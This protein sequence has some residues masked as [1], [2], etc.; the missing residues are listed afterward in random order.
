[1]Y[2]PFSSDSRPTKR[3]VLE[4]E[5]GRA[6][7][8]KSTS[9]ESDLTSLLDAWARL[10]RQLDLVVIGTGC[11]EASL[12]QRAPTSVRF[13]GS[14]TPEEVAAQMA[15][16]R[17]LVFPSISYEGQVLVALEAA[18]AGL[19]MVVSN[20]G[21]MT[22]LFAPHAR[23][24]LF[25][26]GDADALDRRL[27]ALE[28]ADLL[29]AQGAVARRCLEERYSHEVALERLEQIFQKVSATSRGHR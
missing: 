27:D 11:L 22:G 28:D 7:R 10:S 19:P 26:H 12:R 21:A 5:G 8:G 23:E 4:A 3:M 29:D 16:T 20:L 25:P 6:R 15:S 17:A 1:V 2:T 13:L 9:T 24:M 18:A 14:Q